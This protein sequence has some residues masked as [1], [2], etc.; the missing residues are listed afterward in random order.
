MPLDRWTVR[1]VVM[2]EI[3]KYMNENQEIKMIVEES[4]EKKFQEYDKKINDLV[5][6][7]RILNQQINL[8]KEAVEENV[9]SSS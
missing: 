3:Q 9:L 7:I 1:P 4:V 5:E 6:N 8:L 2:E